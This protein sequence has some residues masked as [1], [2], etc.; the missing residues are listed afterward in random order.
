M[1]FRAARGP[2]N[3][4]HAASQMSRGHETGLAIVLPIVSEL[5]NLAGEHLDRIGEIE[6]AILQRP[7]SLGRIEG[8]RHE[9]LYIRKS[10]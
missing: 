4:H 1:P 9:L 3:D 10:M 8:D 6:P 5:E 7:V 2:D